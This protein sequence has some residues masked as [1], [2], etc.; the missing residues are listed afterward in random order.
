[1]GSLEIG[2]RT[3]EAHAYYLTLQEN[4]KSGIAQNEY[5]FF[6]FLY[7][8]YLCFG[9]IFKVNSCG[10]YLMK[11]GIRNTSN[12]NYLAGSVMTLRCGKG[13]TLFGW[14]EYYC[15]WN[16]TWLP[17]NGQWIEEFRDWP[18]CERKYK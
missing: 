2:E 7:S 12:N 11:G 17:T 6:L 5:I 4:M 1:M 13:Y 10:I 8:R 18:Y 9:N 15:N 14:N 16:A 3:R